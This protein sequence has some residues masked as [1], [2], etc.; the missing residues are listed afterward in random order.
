[1]GTLNIPLEEFTF[2]IDSLAIPAHLAS[3]LIAP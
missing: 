2:P 3:H 1:M